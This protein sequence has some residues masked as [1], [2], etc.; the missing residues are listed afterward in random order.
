MGRNVKVFGSA[1]YLGQDQEV[2][3]EVRFGERTEVNVSA[4]FDGMSPIDVRAEITGRGGAYSL[5][6]ECLEQ[7]QRLYEDAQCE[8]PTKLLVVT[9]EKVL[10]DLWR[11]VLVE[12]EEAAVRLD[13]HELVRAVG[14]LQQSPGGELVSAVQA[15]RWCDA[16]VPRL[17]YGSTE[18]PTNN[19]LWE[20]DL[21]ERRGEKRLLKFKTSAVKQ[22]R[23]YFGLASRAASARA[24]A[25]RQGWVEVPWDPQALG[26]LGNWTWED[27]EVP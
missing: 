4:K 25:R 6:T 27:A 12:P 24:E 19:F 26:G 16:Q 3:L 21:D 2:H 10:N 1:P 11:R 8:P 18:H 7:L 23:V 14:A 17:D 13:R 22:G 9:W 15:M 20:A 5:N